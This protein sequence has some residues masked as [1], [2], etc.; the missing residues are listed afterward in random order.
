MSPTM[1]NIDKLITHCI[2][3]LFIQLPRNQQLGLDPIR[4]ICLGA[5]WRSSQIQSRLEPAVH[6]G[7]HR[8]RNSQN[9]LP[10]FSIAD[11]R[12]LSINSVMRNTVAA[13]DSA[14]TRAKRLRLYLSL[15]SKP[16][17]HRLGL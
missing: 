12:N 7:T 4:Y 10:F 15:V 17:V 3:A 16:R 1:T 11:R 6:C 14:W 13:T 5:A 9:A 8:Y 2:I